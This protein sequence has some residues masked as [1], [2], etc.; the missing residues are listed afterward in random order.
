M[1]TDQFTVYREEKGNTKLVKVATFER[2]D[3]AITY[4][5]RAGQIPLSRTTRDRW[6]RHIERGVPFADPGVLG[7]VVIGP[8]VWK[9]LPVWRPDQ[10]LAHYPFLNRPI[11]ITTT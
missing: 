8:E 6:V 11:R 10:P 7:Y 1:S 4:A 9:S 2:C 5:V 3:N